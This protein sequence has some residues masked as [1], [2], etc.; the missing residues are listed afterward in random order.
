MFLAHMVLLNFIFRNWGPMQ[1]EKIIDCFKSLQ[2]CGL[3]CVNFHS[4]TLYNSAVME[5]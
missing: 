3:L 4:V 5:F 2:E 1:S